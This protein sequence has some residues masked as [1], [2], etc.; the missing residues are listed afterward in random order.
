[1][2]TFIA[3]NNYDENSVNDNGVNGDQNVVRN[4]N[5]RKIIKKFIHMFAYIIS[6]CVFV[7]GFIIGFSNKDATLILMSFG[8][9]CIILALISIINTQKYW[10]MCCCSVIGKLSLIFT[11]IFLILMP[12]LGFFVLSENKNCSGFVCLVE[13]CYAFYYIVYSAITLIGFM[14]SCCTNGDDSI[15][16]IDYYFICA[17]IKKGD[18]TDDN[19]GL[20]NV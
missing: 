1:M 17:Y 7:F 14:A 12:M 9:F 6:C 18:I 20:F 11:L 3:Q 16:L 19:D 2:E 8:H 15:M 13:L 10:T 4:R 5:Y